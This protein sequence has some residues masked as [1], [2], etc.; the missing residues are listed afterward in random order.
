MTTH[1]ELEATYAEYTGNFEREMTSWVFGAD[2]ECMPGGFTPTERRHEKKMHWAY[3]PNGEGTLQLFP[4]G[5]YGMVWQDI[6]YDT[7]TGAGKIIWH[8]SE[9]LTEVQRKLLNVYLNNMPETKYGKKPTF[10][11][12]KVFKVVTTREEV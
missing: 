11:G 1:Y 5:E 10:L 7:K 8:L 2:A 3:N 12:L 6:E 9:N 4:H